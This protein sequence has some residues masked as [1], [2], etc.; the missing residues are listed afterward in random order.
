MK[1]QKN[2]KN[3]STKN[4]NKTTSM[5]SSKNSKKN[6]NF[7]KFKFAQGTSMTNIISTLD[8]YNEEEDRQKFIEFLTSSYIRLLR[9]DSR[10]PEI[11]ISFIYFLNEFSSHTN[12]LNYQLIKL[13]TFDLNLCQELSMLRLKNM[14]ELTVEKNKN[15]SSNERFK[16]SKL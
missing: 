14:I 5:S 12:N 16:T 4:M 1:S 6:Y 3:V 11:L 15:S 7:Q 8:F 13:Q 2:N 10:N 9:S